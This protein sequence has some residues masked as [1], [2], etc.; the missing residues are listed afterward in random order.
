MVDKQSGTY[1]KERK[2]F[3]SYNRDGLGTPK[4]ANAVFPRNLTA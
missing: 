4:S 2:N 3:A 1:L